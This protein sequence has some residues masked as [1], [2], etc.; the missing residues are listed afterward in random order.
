MKSKKGRLLFLLAVLLLLLLELFGHTRNLKNKYTTVSVRFFTETSPDSESAAEGGGEEK[1]SMENKKSKSGPAGMELDVMLERKNKD[2]E[3]VTAWKKA[4]TVTLAEEELGRSARAGLYLVRGNMET[5]IP[6]GL[7]A[8]SF[9]YEG[10]TDGCVID[11]E[12]AY[13]LFGTEKAAGCTI[14]FRGRSYQVRGV[15]NTQI[16]I[17]LIQWGND[18]ERYENLEIRTGDTEQAGKMAEELLSAGNIQTSYLL[19]EGGFY[20][21]WA[22]KLA[23]IPVWIL[24]AGFIWCL[25]L[26]WGDNLKK[27]HRINRMSPSQFFCKRCRKDGIPLFLAAMILFAA[28][29]F[30]KEGFLK[31]PFYIPQRFIPTRWSDFSFWGEKWEELKSS[32]YQLIYLIPCPKDIILLESLRILAVQWIGGIILSIMCVFQA[33]N[34]FAAFTKS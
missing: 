26:R 13:G 31:H 16:P 29:F 5:V 22:E 24:T 23:G 14:S 6:A 12:T 28:L 30:L 34:S 27:Q 15:A 32:Y 9:C 20:V 19:V 4:G 18:R 17:F 3:E 21:S 2:I 25:L 1:D 7:I 11:R 10:D 33:K 8:G